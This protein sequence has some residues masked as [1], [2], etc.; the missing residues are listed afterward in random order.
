MSFGID[1]NQLISTIGI[2]G[3]MAIIF[4]ESGLMVGFFLPG[5]T[6]L[7]TAGFLA[8]RGTLGLGMP[9]VGLLIFVAAVAGDNV[10]Y[11]FGR[12]IGRHIFSRQD[13]LLFHRDNLER[14]EKFY[15]RYGPITVL[16]ARFIPVVRT[17][18]PIVAGVGKMRYRTYL[19]YDLAGGFLW[20]MGL[21]YLGY[22][23]GAFFEA[24]GIN[25]DNFILP[26]VG[27]AMLITVLSP[28]VHTLRS[29]TGRAALLKKLRR[30]TA[31]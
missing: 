29:P 18:A 13:S 25:V 15:E 21:T 9:M 30:L 14:A 1:L 10:G 11:A 5:D 24:H 27:A 19:A 17:F 4:S 7:F 16:L 8:T 6:L 31:R 23:A 22:F 28:F 12:R 26:I 2:L 20:A 3:V